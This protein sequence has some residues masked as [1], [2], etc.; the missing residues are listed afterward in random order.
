MDNNRNGKFNRFDMPNMFY[1]I[2]KTYKGDCN[3]MVNMLN[4]S[5]KSNKSNK[6]SVI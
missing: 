4:K 5:N 2:N 3:N 6:N 1:K